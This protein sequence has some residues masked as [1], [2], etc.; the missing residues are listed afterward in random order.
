MKTETKKNLVA[1]SLYITLA[2]MIVTVVCITV[3]SVAKKAKESLPTEESGQ[4]DVTPS[5]TEG[6]DPAGHSTEPTAAPTV[7]E[8]ATSAPTTEPATEKVNAEPADPLP[9]K[10]TLPCEGYVSKGYEADLPVWSN[11]MEDYR[12]HDGI[13]VACELGAEVYSCAAGT[14]E[15]VYEDPLMGNAITVYHGGGLRSTY[16][17]LTGEYPSNIKAGAE[18]AAGQVIGYVGDTA[19]IECADPAH[20]HFVMTMEDETV[21]PLSY[22]EYESAVLS[23]SVEFED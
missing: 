9:D 4:T 1:A 3:I 2:L 15:S 5:R 6:T 13:D 22:I 18:L 17:G 19:L 21:D 8:P 23:D 7:T 20:L 11:T 10:Y 12:I 16:L 14:V